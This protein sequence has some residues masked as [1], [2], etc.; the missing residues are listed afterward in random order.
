[1]G[2]AF[3]SI[4]ALALL[5]GLVVAGP[6]AAETVVKP[7]SLVSHDGRMNQRLESG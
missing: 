2:E 5:L 6:A 4:L 3:Y 1:M 7:T